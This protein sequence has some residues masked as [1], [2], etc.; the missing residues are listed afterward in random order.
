MK[1][2]VQKMN[3]QE[4]EIYGLSRKKIE[5]PNVT[6]IEGDLLNSKDWA[7]SLKN[8]DII[9]HA[10]AIT[11]S[12]DPQN[13]YRINT[14]ATID[15]INLAIENK[16]KKFIFISSRTASLKAGAYGISKLWA[17]QYLKSQH[18]THLIIRPSEI[19]GGQKG[20]GIDQLI[21]Q[22]RTKSFIACP[23]QLKEKLWPISLKDTVDITFNLMMN[24]DN[25]N[26]TF[27]INGPKPYSLY[28]I[29][30]IS[31]LSA[32]NKIL[33]IPI[34]KFI[35]LFVWFLS[36][37]LKLKFG[38]KPDQILRLYAK[39]EV[40]VINYPFQS[41]ESYLEGLNV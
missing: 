26:K 20:E 38:P 35:M 6:I 34:P 28:D 33:I 19:F 32:K 24:D 1:R 29:I 31:S 17:E 22:S 9:I 10:A 37:T 8:S 25:N 7:N 21:Q 16:I 40:Q 2:L 14:N 18:L 4:Y 11:H 23:I 13:Y 39:K 5:I 3:L 27:V 36:K 15:L 12:Y 30:Q 41:L